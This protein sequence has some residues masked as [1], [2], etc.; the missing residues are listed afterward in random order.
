MNPLRARLTELAEARDKASGEAALDAGLLAAAQERQRLE[1]EIARA[2]GAAGA[3]AQPVLKRQGSL[4][5]QFIW[6]SRRPLRM[7]SAGG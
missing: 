3:L 5:I 6:Q 2:E 4:L 7:F 1:I